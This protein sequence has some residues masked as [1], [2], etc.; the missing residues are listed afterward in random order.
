MNV[1]YSLGYAMH[2]PGPCKHLTCSSSVEQSECRLTEKLVR[3]RLSWNEA[4]LEM[5]TTSVL[6][7]LLLYL[8]LGEL[9]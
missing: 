9:H 1:M 8:T 3:R 6:R 2:W 5:N 4:L 7:L